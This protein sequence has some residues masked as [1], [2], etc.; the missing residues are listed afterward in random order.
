MK[1]NSLYYMLSLLLTYSKI[2]TLTICYTLIWMLKITTKYKPQ[3]FC[4]GY[5]LYLK[6]TGKIDIC[7]GIPYN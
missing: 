2:N 1:I 6:F 5:I 3:I 7:L 4:F